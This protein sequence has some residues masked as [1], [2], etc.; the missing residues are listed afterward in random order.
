ML[1]PQN[2][3][4]KLGFQVLSDLVFVVLSLCVHVYETLPN[5]RRPARR[6][7]LGEATGGLDAVA[8]FGLYFHRH[9]AGLAP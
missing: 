6:E 3:E 8:D 2:A 7:P 4:I 9:G 1:G 5:F